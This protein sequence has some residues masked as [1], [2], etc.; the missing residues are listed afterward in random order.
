MLKSILNLAA[1]ILFLNVISCTTNQNPTQKPPGFL[2]NYSLLK[3]VPSPEGTKIYTYLAPDA[4]R[5]NYHAAIIMPVTLYQSATESG[6]TAEQIEQ[7]RKNIASGVTKIVSKKITITN[8]SGPGV[9]KIYVSITGATLEGEGF[10]P[11]NLI[12]ISAAIKL[13]SKATDLDNK[14]PIMVVEIK[15]LDSQSSALL[16]EVVSIINGEEFRMSIHTAD[17]FQKLAIEWVNQALKYS[18]NK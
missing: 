8:T 1:V 17:E 2:P 7:A 9:A 6:V 3:E 12:P 16:K 4:K 13:A 14:K 18:E 11:R 15:V 5:N 10:K